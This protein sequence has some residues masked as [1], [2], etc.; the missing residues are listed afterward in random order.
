MSTTIKINNENLANY[1]M[2]KL[3]K[4]RNEFTQEELNEIS[5]IV[6]DYRDEAESGFVFLEELKNLMFLNL[7]L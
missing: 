3:N 6:I 7:L 2:F 4:S 5:E 1:V